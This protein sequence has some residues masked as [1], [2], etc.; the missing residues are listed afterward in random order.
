MLKRRYLALSAMFPLSI[1]FNLWVNTPEQAPSPLTSP[2]SIPPDFRFER[3]QRWPS[4]QPDKLVLWESS[5][6][7]VSRLNEPYDA[8]LYVRVE[9][10]AR[11][12]LGEECGDSL[13]VIY[14]PS[15]SEGR[16]ASGG[17]VPEIFDPPGFVG[18]GWSFA[19]LGLATDDA[20][21]EA[22]VAVYDD[23][24]FAVYYEP[25]RAG[26]VLYKLDRTFGFLKWYKTIAGLEGVKAQDIQIFADE[27]VV[28]LQVVEDRRAFV[29]EANSEDGEL[30]RRVEVPWE[31]VRA[32]TQLKRQPPINQERLK[33]TSSQGGAPLTLHYAHADKQ[34]GWKLALAHASISTPVEHDGSLFFASYDPGLSGVMVYRLD[35]ESGELIWAQRAKLSALEPKQDLERPQEVTLHVDA[36]HGLVLVESKDTAHPDRMW[37]EILEVKTGQTLARHRYLGMNEHP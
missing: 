28:K 34:R 22:R 33:M 3:S 35:R 30:R 6:K 19:P 29:L 12:R 36:E 8:S 24:I 37:Q 11:E 26:G 31:L 14:R 25:G 27:D 15:S 1:A 10:P 4:D 21:L 2:Q 7:A 23:S 20:V 32:R 9:P 16:N 18:S 13:S 5:F 17:F